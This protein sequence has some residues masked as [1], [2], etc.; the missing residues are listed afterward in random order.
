[1]Y[2]SHNIRTKII[3]ISRMEL[4]CIM[5]IQYLLSLAFAAVISAQ[6]TPIGT[7]PGTNV[8]V[9]DI[10]ID[11]GDPIAFE[12]FVDSK[13]SITYDSG[14]SL[15][16]RDDGDETV[17]RVLSVCIPQLSVS[18]YAN[19]YHELL[20][21]YPDANTFKGS[22]VP[23][24][25]I[26]T[27]SGCEKDTECKFTL[28]MSTELSLA[29]QQAITT[30]N[31]KSYSNTIGSTY[32]VGKGDDFASTITNSTDK[33]FTKG[34]SFT[35]GREWSTTVSETVTAG[36]EKTDTTIKGTEHS[37]GSGGGT[38]NTYTRPDCDGSFRMGSDGSPKPPLPPIGD[39]AGKDP[40][41]KHLGSSLEFNKAFYTHMLYKRATKA[42][43]CR[44][45][46][47]EGGGANLG[48][49]GGNY[50]H[51]SGWENA[52]ISN[53]TRTDFNEN[54][55]ENS[56]EQHSKTDFENT[57]TMNSN[58]NGGSWSST[59]DESNTVS[60]GNSL[61]R[62][63]TKRVDITQGNNTDTTNGNTTENSDYKSLSNTTTSTMTISR[64]ITVL[65]G[66]CKMWVCHP[67]SD[68]KIIPYVCVNSDQVYQYR[69][70]RIISPRK[71]S[72]QYG[73]VYI[74]TDC[75]DYV[76][77]YIP[78]YM[79]NDLAK[80]T[81]TN[82]IVSGQY[83]Q[84]VSGS[85]DTIIS[86]NKDYK[87]ELKGCNLRLSKLETVIWQSNTDF[88]YPLGTSSQACR[89]RFNEYGHF[90]LET[91][92]AIFSK[93]VGDFRKGQWITIWSTAPIHHSK[94]V[95]GIPRDLMDTTD[96]YK[97]LLTDKGR[98]D[99]YDAAGINT[100][101]AMDTQSKICQHKFGYIAPENYL[102]PL[103]IFTNG[104]TQ[105]PFDPHTQI[106]PGIKLYQDTLV[107]IDKNCSSKLQSGSGIVSNNGR[108]ALILNPNG[109]LVFKEYG[110][111]MWESFSANIKNTI[112]PYYL[113]LSTNGVMFIRDSKNYVTWM[114]NNTIASN[115]APYKLSVLDEGRFVVTNN[116]SVVEWENWPMNNLS[117]G[118][119]PTIMPRICFKICN[120][121]PITYSNV[122]VNNTIVYN[123][124]Q[125]TN[126]ST[127]YTTSYTSYTNPTIT[128]MLPVPTQVP[129]PVS[130]KDIC[131]KWMI[132]YKVDPVANNY[133]I[134][135]AGT[136][137]LA[138]QYR[139]KCFWFADKCG[140][141]PYT[142]I[143][144]LTGAAK[145]EWYNNKCN[146]Y[147]AQ[148]KYNVIG[149]NNWGSLPAKMQ[150]K[151][152]ADSCDSLT[153]STITTTTINPTPSIN[154][155]TSMITMTNM[156]TNVYTNMYT[157]NS[158]STDTNYTTTTDFVDIAYITN[159]TYYVYPTAMTNITTA[160]TTG[161]TETFIVATPTATST[162]PTPTPTCV[163]QTNSNSGLAGQCCNTH[164]DCKD[165]CNNGI[166]GK[167]GVNFVCKCQGGNPGAGKRNGI[168]GQCCRSDKDCKDN[169]RN[170]TCGKCGYDFEC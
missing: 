88:V 32:S 77:D 87:F 57:A 155:I 1:M 46:E 165:N 39:I 51:G 166:C 126:N 44:T 5:K 110:R 153:Y 89:A 79:F 78:P 95:I 118:L 24:P 25:L 37:K 31:S 3:I 128:T 130:Y 152:T 154:P 54:N 93:A 34:K 63:T 40:G 158:T 82:T 66:G 36:W 132:D 117:V 100:W 102:V 69:F 84:K 138:T 106:A 168:Y 169:C 58:T 119:N 81:S 136:I 122:T 9:Y 60:Y 129:K 83:L 85:T 142:S 17:K 114:S 94:I 10:F 72:G 13:A 162:I 73:C 92:K 6:D 113:A 33:S 80:S 68:V 124:T 143:G 14:N 104:T 140:A 144:T 59:V 27:M 45:S 157:T 137:A 65:P 50:E 97:L 86:T 11:N 133:G 75:Q 16:K 105:G 15:R 120:E 131:M 115:A 76:Y 62:T 23:I 156:T 35:N 61:A 101:C 55:S 107:S 103:D 70:N 67:I 98:L 96:Q 30:S 74:T 21:S 135:D 111:T 108:F 41:G 49:I 159:I 125:I 148:A 90:I 91:N 147:T 149:N 163:P 160:I 53:G 29:Y 20:L 12:D 161:I 116:A 64:E 43:S 145:S 47:N 22:G 2:K 164:H 109:N 121:C 99:I 151:W 19:P 127:N 167:C 7:I 170:E 48:P 4:L 71:E 8:K 38:D 18:P 134:M 150:P 52:N 141:D 123:T 42:D 28:T 26:S 112:K 56:S 139:C 146:C